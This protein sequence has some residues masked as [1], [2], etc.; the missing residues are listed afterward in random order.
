MSTPLPT[1]CPT[2]GGGITK[3]PAKRGPTSDLRERL[4]AHYAHG[5]GFTATEAAAQLGA[6]PTQVKALLHRLAIAGLADGE[7]MPPKNPRKGRPT[8]RGRATL[9]RL[10]A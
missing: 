10:V 7:P 6:T 3:P 1:T 4:L 5:G 8:A 2:C 9:W